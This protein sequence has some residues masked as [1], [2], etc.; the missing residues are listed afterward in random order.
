M[1]EQIQGV[2][3]I[4]DSSYET[5]LTFL[6]YLYTGNIMTSGSVVE[7]DLQ[8]LS[9]LLV[10]ADRYMLE[11]LRLSCEKRM[12]NYV[13]LSNVVTIYLISLEY[14]ASQ[15]K[16]NASTNSKITDHLSSNLNSIFLAEL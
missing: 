8:E 11:H 12:E 9:D 13:D 6:L 14:N 15:L 10:L 2:I 3:R 4:S 7:S 5:F 1:K 16:G